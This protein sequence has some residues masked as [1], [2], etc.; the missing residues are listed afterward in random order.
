MSF[1]KQ[2]NERLILIIPEEV[3][4][5]RPVFPFFVVVR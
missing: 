3:E 1:N 2:N 5:D 4:D